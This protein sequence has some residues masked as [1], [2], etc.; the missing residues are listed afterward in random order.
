MPNHHK[1]TRRPGN[2][3]LNEQ[4]IV[5]FAH[6]H[7]TQI[8]RR[9]ATITHMA[10]HPHIL[11]DTAWEQT[12]TDCAT[13]TVPAL[14]AMGHVTARKLVTSHNALK[15]FALTGTNNVHV[16][17]GLKFLHRDLVADVELDGFF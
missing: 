16:L 6:L 12:L 11:E 10:G 4:K 3:T 7:H 8:L 9:N 13:A 2:R 15:S 17:T 5:Y 14:R 1:R